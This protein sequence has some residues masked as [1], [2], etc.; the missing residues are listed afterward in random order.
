MLP[1]MEGFLVPRIDDELCTDCGA[2]A[3]V[4]PE[5]HSSTP[6]RDMP[7]QAFA[8]WNRDGDVRMKSASGGVFSVL[9][10]R[11]L[12]AGGTVCGAAFDENLAV[13]HILVHDMHSL[14]RLRSSKYVQSDIG[15]TYREVKAYLRSR[16]QVLFSGTPC[17]VAGLYGFLGKDYDNLIT[18]DVLC[19]GVPSPLYFSHF[20]C[21]LEYHF[22]ARISGINF[23][24]K[25]YDWQWNSVFV[26]FSGGKEKCLSGH[27]KGYLRAFYRGLSLREAC[28]NCH[29]SATKRPGDISLGD[30]WGIGKSIPFEHPTRRGISLGIVNSPKGQEL[31]VR[32]DSRLDFEIRPLHEAVEKNRALSQP[33]TRPPERSQFYK[34]LLA[35]SF[36]EV[37]RKYQLTGRFT[38]LQKI[39]AWKAFQVIRFKLSSIILGS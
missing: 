36:E 13:K 7:P 38:I 10:D 17:Q 20:L 27:Q 15:A 3:K 39:L 33:T 26:Q 34:D 6:R 23:R 30:F 28:Y 14:C 19:H 21:Y 4:C 31:F 1:D 35:M 32:S 18:C 9:A 29:Y 11:V 37:N 24:D 8:C 12:C 16:K 25:R 22:G 2:C 5:L